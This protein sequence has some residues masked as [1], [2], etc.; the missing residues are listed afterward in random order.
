MKTR[1]SLVAGLG[2]GAMV[3]LGIVS[4]ESKKA[5][6]CPP[7]VAGAW[8]WKDVY[9]L[10][11]GCKVTAFCDIKTDLHTI[12]AVTKTHISLYGLVTKNYTISG[13]MLLLMDATA[14]G[15]H[16]PFRRQASVDVIPAGCAG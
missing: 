10:I 14:T 12:G 13:D 15:V 7:G 1:W 4:C 9:L 16:I 11:D 5:A 8:Q 3:S 6:V 2:L